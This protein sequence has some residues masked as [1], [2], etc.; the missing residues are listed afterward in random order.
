MRGAAAAPLC[1]GALAGGGC[2]GTAQTTPT[3]ASPRG[4]YPQL[5]DHLGLGTTTGA[6]VQTVGPGGPGADAGL[7]GGGSPERFQEQGYAV[8]GDV[9]TA[10]DG[11]PLR[12][13]DDLG[14]T[15]SML[16]PGR[17]V[18]LRVVRDGRTHEV[19]LKLGTRP[20]DSPRG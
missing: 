8:G 4:R 20:L 11:T 9:I 10:P 19:R 15:L 17:Q 14:Q 12:G 18:T 16:D 2:G 5:S 3:S 6:R 7:R 13:K 1:G